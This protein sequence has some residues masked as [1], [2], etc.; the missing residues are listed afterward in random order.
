MNSEN[1]EG[2]KPT[3]LRSYSHSKW[4]PAEIVAAFLDQEETCMGKEYEDEAELRKLVDSLRQYLQRP[5]G[6]RLGVSVHKRGRFVVL[7]KKGEQND[8]R[9]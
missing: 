6:R 5:Q 1:L 8:L 7:C 2:F 3:T 4:Q 9:I